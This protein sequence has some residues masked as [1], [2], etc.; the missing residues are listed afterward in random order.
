MN[1]GRRDIR[2]WREKRCR[3]RNWRGSRSR[4]YPRSPVESRASRPAESDIA[5]MTGEDARRSTAQIIR[6]SMRRLHALQDFGFAQSV[7]AR[8]GILIY[9]LDYLVVRRNDAP[10]Q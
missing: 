6:R 10:L 1:S 8:F 2:S 5:R 9:P 4:T 7:V 3:V